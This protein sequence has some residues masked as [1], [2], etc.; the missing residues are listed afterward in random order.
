[1]QIYKVENHDAEIVIGQQQKLYNR[2]AFILHP[3]HK[4]NSLLQ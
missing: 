1:M 2:Y 3:F 4:I